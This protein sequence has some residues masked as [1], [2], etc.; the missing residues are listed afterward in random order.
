MILQMDSGCVCG[1]HPVAVVVSA[2]ELLSL[3]LSL[4]HGVHGLQVR[5]VGYQRQR[6]VPV[7]HAVDTTMVHPQ[8]VLHVSGALRR[9][10]TAGRPRL[11]RLLSAGIS[12][13][14]PTGRY[15]FSQSTDL[16]HQ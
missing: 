5:R 13:Q 11:K 3:G 6:D 4:H 9:E 10:S 1:S 7:R 16:N 15:R 12:S 14:T 2:V 8:M